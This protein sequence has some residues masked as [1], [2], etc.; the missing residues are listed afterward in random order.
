MSS[1][2]LCCIRSTQLRPPVSRSERDI[3]QHLVTGSRRPS[4][5]LLSLDSRVER[6]ACAP[7]DVV[8]I[9]RLEPI[10]GSEMQ[11]L[12]EQLAPLDSAVS[13]AVSK[14]TEGNPFYA[15][16]LIQLLHLE[17]FLVEQ[18]GR[19][20]IAAG[21]SSASWP[22]TLEDTLRRRAEVTL[23]RVEPTGIAYDLLMACSILG[24]A[25]DFELLTGFFRRFTAENISI[26]RH[27]E[28]FI[29][30]NLLQVHHSFDFE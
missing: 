4:A 2:R 10:L 1:W 22:S 18:G 8:E 13:E 27:V 29:D 7:R 25:F 14:I 15:T 11:A 16:E 21:E 6:V 19:L 24:E 23:L 28:M 12:L 5:G 17:G 20:T 9:R 30:L 3:R 26:E